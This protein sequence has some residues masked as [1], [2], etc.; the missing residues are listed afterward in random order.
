M[1]IAFLHSVLRNLILYFGPIIL[2]SSC[3]ILSIG[4]IDT[5][6]VSLIQNNFYNQIAGEFNKNKP[7]QTQNISIQDEFYGKIIWNNVDTK[8]NSPEWLK[9]VSETNL[10]RS[11]L[12]LTGKSLTYEPYLPL[13]TEKTNNQQ[14]NKKP[15]WLNNLTEGSDKLLE[16]FQDQTKELNLPKVNLP[17][18]LEIPKSP[19]DNE[20]LNSINPVYQVNQTWVKFWTALRGYYWQLQNLAWAAITVYGLLLLGLV[21]TSVF[22]GKS[23]L[24]EFSIITRRLGINILVSTIFFILSISGVFLLGAV[25]K[26]LIPNSFLIGNIATIVNWQIV[27]LIVSTM[28]PALAIGILC[29]ISGLITVIIRTPKALR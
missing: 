23:L 27:W 18:N 28:A 11:H 7:N 5:Y 29:T 4:N 25:I 1:S 22:F 9:T 21:L 19:I 3:L 14:D 6:K 26:S 15:D 12:W 8:F 20:S 2:I 10:E 13:N 16:R 24:E 17:T